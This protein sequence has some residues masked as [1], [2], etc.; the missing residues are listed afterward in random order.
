MTRREALLDIQARNNGLLIPRIVIE[1]ARP[2]DSPLHN[3][4]EWDDTKAAARYR[5]LQAQELIRSIKI[6]ECD[7]EPVKVT[8]FVNLSSD[9]TDSSENNGYR[10]IL[11]IK[12]CPDLMDV[13]VND[14]L[15]ALE[16]VRRKFD[17][18]RSLQ[19]V[20]DAIDECKQS[21]KPANRP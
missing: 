13:A 7:K 2:V 19:K 3:A 8:M 14:A 11:D 17:F 4:F 6:T 9:R 15:Q 18:L 1:E 10:S 12:D 16:G 5:I 21:R 20:W